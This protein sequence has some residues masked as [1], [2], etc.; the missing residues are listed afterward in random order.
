MKII[1]AVFVDGGEIRSGP[2][3]KH[4]KIKKKIAGKVKRLQ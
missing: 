4:E 2:P 3:P 1:D